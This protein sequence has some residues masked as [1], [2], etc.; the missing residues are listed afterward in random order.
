MLIVGRWWKLM[1]GKWF[2]DIFHTLNHMKQVAKYTFNPTMNHRSN[3][4][5]NFECGSGV[6]WIIRNNHVNL[7]WIVADHWQV[8]TYTNEYVIVTLVLLVIL[9]RTVWLCAFRMATVRGS[10]GLGQKVVGICMY[11]LHFVKNV[12]PHGN[13]YVWAYRMPFTVCLKLLFA[14]T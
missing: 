5:V 14:M 11:L 4:G 9:V 1:V 8:A 6:S 2:L 13:G 7:N 3:L 12:Q 10:G